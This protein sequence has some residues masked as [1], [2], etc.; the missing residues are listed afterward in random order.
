MGPCRGEV[1]LAVGELSVEAEL[2]LGSVAAES[3][4]KVGPDFTTWK[5]RA[6]HF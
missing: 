6:S 3:E 1:D 4:R 5:S 2:A